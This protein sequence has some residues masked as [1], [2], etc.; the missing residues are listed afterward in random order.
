MPYS[1]RPSNIGL[2]KK[3]QKFNSQAMPKFAFHLIGVASADKLGI[4]ES[5][6]AVFVSFPVSLTLDTNFIL[7][8]PPGESPQPATLR[9]KAMALVAKKRQ[10]RAQSGFAPTTGPQ[11]ASTVP[12]PSTTVDGSFRMCCAA[13]PSSSSHH[14]CE[15]CRQPPAICGNLLTHAQPPPLTSHRP[16]AFRAMVSRCLIVVPSFCFSVLKPRLLF[17][18]TSA[19]ATSP[20]PSPPSPPPSPPSP[21][22]RRHPRRP[23]LVTPALL[24][25]PA[26]DLSQLRGG[27]HDHAR[28]P[29]CSH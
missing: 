1:Q 15:Q 2:K 27:R 22:H 28:A 7:V 10:E 4:G 29:I 14:S 16:N 24:V 18:H 26:P 23:D 25:T 19:T 6:S 17:S 9:E 21:R 3:C 5:H 8:L 13:R 20:P 11:E 12:E